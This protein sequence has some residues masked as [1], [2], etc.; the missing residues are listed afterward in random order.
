M[1]LKSMDGKQLK[2]IDIDVRISDLQSNYL[3]TCSTRYKGSY[4]KTIPSFNEV[5]CHIPNV[6]LAPGVYRI[7][8]WACMRG[9]EEDYIENAGRLVVIEGDFFGTGKLPVPGKHGPFLVDHA[10]TVRR[11]D[12]AS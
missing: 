5:V 11:A 7:D 12:C 4:I 9:V 8:L 1:H 3:L 2:N 10:W 6:P